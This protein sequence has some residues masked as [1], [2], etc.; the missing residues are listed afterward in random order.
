[1]ANFKHIRHLKILGELSS[2]SHYTEVTPGDATGVWKHGSVWV[3][4]F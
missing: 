4:M 2:A 1:M 3:C